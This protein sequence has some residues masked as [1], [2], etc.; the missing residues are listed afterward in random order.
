MSTPQDP[1]R[2]EFLQAGAA[3]LAA[4]G[5][6]GAAPLDDRKNEGGIPLRPLGDERRA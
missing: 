4:V 2:R 1:T 3:G 5:I 6:A